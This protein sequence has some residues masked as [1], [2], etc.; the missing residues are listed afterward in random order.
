MNNSMCAIPWSSVCVFP[1]GNA[2]PCCNMHGFTLDKSLGNVYTTELSDIINH[3]NYRD[4]RVD[5]MNG[6]L[7]DVCMRCKIS[8]T[9]MR[10]YVNRDLMHFEDVQHA[11]ESTDAEGFVDPEKF[12]FK[13]WD[14]RFS[15][16]CNF[17]CRMCNATN[18]S[19]IQIERD[20]HNRNVYSIEKN[21]DT[22]E[23][24]INENID[25][26]AVAYFT[27]GEPMLMKEHW[28]ILNKLVELKRFDV[29]LKYTI[30]CSTLSYAGK[31]AI[32]YWNL[33]DKKQI[34]ITNSIDD[35]GQR[36]EYQRNRRQM[37]HYSRKS[38]NY[39]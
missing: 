38:K 35:I 18:S 31:N 34:R 37:E 27:G 22:W 7:P 26:L 36:L 30:N 17:S 4:M 20:G 23:K 39:Q 10:E 6:K 9:S 32:D 8:K 16:I 13:Y 15:N 21:F 1:D 3:K 12:K 33:F 29:I 14:F 25:D 28:Y 5:M 19:A 2:R 11:I 24:I